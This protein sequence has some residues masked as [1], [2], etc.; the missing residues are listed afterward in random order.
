MK[1]KHP[2]SALSHKHFL[3]LYGSIYEHS[4]WVA[5]AAWALREEQNIDSV[6]G[7]HLAM[8][9]AVDNA[10]DARKLA[11]LRAHPELACAKGDLTEASKS[12]QAGAGLKHCTADEFE[13][14]QELNDGY[15]KKFGFPFI[16]AVKGLNKQ[17]I[18]QSFRARIK[19]APADEFV[20]AV[21]Q[22]HRIA[23]FRLEA[24]SE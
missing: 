6:E 4:P 3:E 1:L 7:L 12:E 15:Y 17:D 19:H 9:H 13:E 23:H 14:F 8:S 16:V 22:V 24:L 21:A 11:L 5:D 18:L 20:T 10:E 2:P